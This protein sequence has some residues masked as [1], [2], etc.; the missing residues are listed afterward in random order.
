MSKVNQIR[1]VMGIQAPRESG[2]LA[3]GISA[4]SGA[5]SEPTP[6]DNLVH[7]LEREEFDLVAVGRAVLADPL[8][9]AKVHA[10]DYTAMKGFT[11]AAL[12]ELV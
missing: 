6:L 8:W 2:V 4:F 3:V 10:G 7:R 9:A 12:R 5:S 11:P 1:T